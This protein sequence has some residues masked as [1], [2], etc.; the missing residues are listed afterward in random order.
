MIAEN[1]ISGRNFQY[2]R[3]N[4][5]IASG[6]CLKRILISRKKLSDFFLM[7]LIYLTRCIGSVDKIFF[8][9]A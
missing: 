7:I 4:S 3:K 1:F 2:L 9:F 8:Y 6:L 5:E